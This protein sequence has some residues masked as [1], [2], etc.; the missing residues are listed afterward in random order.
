MTRTHRLYLDG[1]VT[2]HGGSWLAGVDNAQPGLM[3]PGA[4]SAGQKFHQER[5]P[6]VAEDESKILSTS[7]SI[8]VPAGAVVM[9]CTWQ[10]A[11]PMR[12]PIQTSPYAS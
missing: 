4:P 10:V 6:G 9:D 12:R 3:I 7:E 2:G 11:Q 1:Q 8:T 5:A